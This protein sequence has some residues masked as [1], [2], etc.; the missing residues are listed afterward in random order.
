VVK[1]SKD[2]VEGVVVA[3]GQGRGSTLAQSSNPAGIFVDNDGTLY[4]VEKENQRVT[5]WVDAGQEDVVIAG[6]NGIGQDANQLNAPIG[7]S[8]D[9]QGNMYVADS[10]NGRV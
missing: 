6:G 2:A 10:S 7:L 8:F 9:R 3:G 4:L 5:R 1:L